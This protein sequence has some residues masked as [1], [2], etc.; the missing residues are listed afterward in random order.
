MKLAV[1]GTGTV[2][3]VLGRRWAA[4]GHQVIFGTRDPGSDKV[5]DLLAEA[6]SNAGAAPVAEAVASSEVVVL[7]TPW[8]A[9]RDI[10]EG[11]T[12]WGD[13]I[14]VD[15]T[16]PIGPGFALAVGHTTSGAEQVAE[17]A[18][19][20]RVVKAFN[21]TGAENMADPVYQS[22]PITMFI[23]GDDSE[24]KAVVTQLG[25]VLGFEVTDTGN[26]AMARHLEPLA[27]VW[28]NLAIVRQQGRDI[29]FKLVRR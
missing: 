4:Q 21:T 11:I 5:Q 13:K 9:V 6:G 14:I 16:N 23:C 17:W 22:Q 12:E 18:R 26:L 15:C 25:E 7:A 27:M 3:S 24:A 8:P 29:A 19:S 20:R 1:I 28:I 2:G 10:V